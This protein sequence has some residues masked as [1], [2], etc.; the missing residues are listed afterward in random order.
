VTL[1]VV[2][3]YL[4]LLL[5]IDLPPLK[6]RLSRCIALEDFGKGGPPTFLFA[7]RKKGRCNPQG[8]ECVYFSEG[9]KTALAE[10]TTYWA[11][12]GDQHQP[13]LVFHA[14][15]EL[16]HTIDLTVDDARKKLSISDQDLYGAWRTRSK[17]TLLQELG[18]ALAVQ[19]TAS[20]IRYPSAAARMA[21]FKG[22]NVVVFRAALVPPS[23]LVI[24]GRRGKILERWP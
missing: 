19:N 21:G 23:R 22:V 14:E 7:S 5:T 17:P 8:A 16:Q 2:K 20:A 13:K 10:F 1:A 3:R 6:T 11:P 18:A 24:T 15:V 9:E 12:F 4:D